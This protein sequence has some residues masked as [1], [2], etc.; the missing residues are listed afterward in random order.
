MS[1]LFKYLLFMTLKAIS[2]V[3]YFLRILKKRN[4]TLFFRQIKIL[5]DL[6]ILNLSILFYSETLC[7]ISMR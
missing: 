6:I 3:R 4:E 1:M 5:S 7:G 2:T